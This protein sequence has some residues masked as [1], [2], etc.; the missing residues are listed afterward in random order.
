MDF[1]TE[2]TRSNQNAVQS[3]LVPSDLSEL[4]V[5][6]KKWDNLGCSKV[7]INTKDSQ[8]ISRQTLYREHLGEVT[9]DIADTATISEKN[10]LPDLPAYPSM[11]Q[12]DEKIVNVGL[13]Q[14]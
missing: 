6:C 7:K 3:H 2:I 12:G 5:S 11:K 14:Q 1:L 10:D 4:F 8:E 9:L 13:G